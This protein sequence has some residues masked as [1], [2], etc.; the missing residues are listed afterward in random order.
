M[1]LLVC[2]GGH[3]NVYIAPT[4]CFVLLDG[5][6]IFRETNESWTE[7]SEIVKKLNRYLFFYSKTKTNLHPITSLFTS[8]Y[9]NQQIRIHLYRNWRICNAHWSTNRYIQINYRTVTIIVIRCLLEIKLV[10]RKL[11]IA[12]SRGVT[13]GLRR[14]SIIKYYFFGFVSWN[15]LAY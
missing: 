14:E 6:A 10:S 8:R 15:I 12:G 5:A 7:L 2:I 13:Q 11:F 9:L 1:L 4:L 3:K